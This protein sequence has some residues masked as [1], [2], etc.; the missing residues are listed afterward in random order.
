[1]LTPAS[2]RVLKKL[3]WPANP[4]KREN[5][6]ITNCYER[7]FRMD[8]IGVSDWQVGLASQSLPI[9]TDHHQHVGTRN[10]IREAFA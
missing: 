7:L 3:R 6:T 9:R 10:R 4:C 2:A 5:R 8:Q 1:M